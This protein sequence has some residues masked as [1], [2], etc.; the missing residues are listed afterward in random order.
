MLVDGLAARGRICFTTEEAERSL[1]TTPVAA[2]AVLRRLRERAEIATPIRG[3]HVILPPECRSAGCRPAI[4]FID[5][6]ANYLHTPYYL[7]LLSA[8]E[9][10][11]AAHQRPQ[12][13]QVMLPAR[14]R[15]L[16][17]GSVDIE[18]VLRENAAGV[19][20]VVKNTPAGTI[21]VSTP[22]ATALD[23]V[24][25][26][27]HCG[28]LGNVATVLKELAEEM[29]S[30]ALARLQSGSPAA[31][32]QRLG[33]LLDLVGAG[34]IAEDLERAVAA[35]PPVWTYLDPRGP[36]AGTRDKRWRLVANTTVE[37]D[38]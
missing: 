34:E 20:V 17:C 3:F 23:L 19:P 38:Q 9:L 37:T 11:G 8:A 5:Y 2:K 27:D 35:T 6:L 21:R 29:S 36:R 1:A 22:E 28:G 4:E 10:H 30:A 26:V 13:N 15:S 7:A 18:F 24:G 14:R 16:R 32:S 25:Y 12:V 31:W 33:Y